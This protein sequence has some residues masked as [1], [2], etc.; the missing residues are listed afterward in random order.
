MS[1]E[2]RDYRN[3]GSGYAAV[4]RRRQQ[5]RTKFMRRLIFTG[6]ILIAV[7]FL[8]MS[9]F[10]IYYDNAVSTTSGGEL[11]AEFATASAIKDDVINILMCGIDYEEGRSEDEYFG[12]T[13]V[14]LYV[15]YDS[16]GGK[17][18]MFQIPRDTYVGKKYK[19][20]GTD[21]I[22]GVYAHNTDGSMAALAKVIY[23]DFGLPVDH[24]ITINMEALKAVVNAIDG[25]DMYIPRDIWDKKTGKLV[26]AQGDLFIDGTTAEYIVRNRNYANADIDRLSVQRYFYAALFRKFKGFPIGDIIKLM[27]YYVTFV[28][29]DMSLARLGSIARAFMSIEAENILVAK[30]PGEGYRIDNDIE[31][32]STHK[33]ATA[34]LLNLYFR[35]YGEPIPADELGLIE[36]ANTNNYLDGSVQIMSGIIDKEEVMK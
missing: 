13:D 31:V 2:N 17:I 4:L 21:K 24:Y 34:D 26:A 33:S 32:F 18:S 29:T 27:P 19:T 14:I 9:G 25:L 16:K 10:Y 6:M 30:M 20:G 35:T 15:H 22:N 23:D 3:I 36:L 8:I 1:N 5:V 7:A 12:M 11:P 28:E